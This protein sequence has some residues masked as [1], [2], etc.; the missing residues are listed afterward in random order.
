MPN[1]P[2]DPT[3]YPRDRR[4]IPIHLGL[5]DGLYVFVQNIDEIIYVLPDHPH[6]HPKVLGG[7]KPARYAGDLTVENGEIRD[8]TNLSGTFQFDDR[9]GLLGL[10]TH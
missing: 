9:V 1:W 5:R 7:G 3:P 2:L 4:S 6:A 8:L 10:Q